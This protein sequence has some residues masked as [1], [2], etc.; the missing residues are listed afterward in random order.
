IAAEK[1]V[2]RSSSQETALKAIRTSLGGGALKTPEARADRKLVRA[3]LDKAWGLDP[4][5]VAQ[6]D[7]LFGQDAS[8][9][10]E[11]VDT[12]P[13]GVSV[14]RTKEL[15]VKLKDPKGGD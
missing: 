5:V 1:D 4:A 2:A 14:H 8:K 3:E 15:A 6:L 11:G 9:T 7:K 12:L 13:E 10:L